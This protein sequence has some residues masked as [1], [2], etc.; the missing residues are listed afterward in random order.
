LDNNGVRKP[1][2]KKALQFR[3]GSHALVRIQAS[4]A[5]EFVGILLDELNHTAV[6]RFRAVGC[7]A[8]AARDDGFDY[9]ILFEVL[10]N[11]RQAL[12]F[13]ELT[14]GAHILEHG[15]VGDSRDNLRC[16]RPEA[17]IYNFH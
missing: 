9:M 17:K 4:E 14:G 7:L 6:I 13:H 10:H 16:I 8:I 1:R 5:D 11:L 15:A 12:R 2:I 3:D